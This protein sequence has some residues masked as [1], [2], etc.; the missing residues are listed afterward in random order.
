M[1]S[2]QQPINKALLMIISSWVAWKDGRVG[3]SQ[4]HLLSQIH[5]DNSHIGATNP[6]N[7]RKTLQLIIERSPHIK[8][9]EGQS[10]G[11]ETN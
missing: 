3:G 1:P 5:L 2:I 4:A 7:E 11:Q 9:E 8:E 10:P 6:E